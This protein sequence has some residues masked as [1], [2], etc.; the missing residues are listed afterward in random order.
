MI[1]RSLSPSSD[2]IH[3]QG[4]GERADP[5][6]GASSVKLAIAFA[7]VAV[8]C[9][10]SCSGTLAQFYDLTTE[11]NQAISELPASLGVL[12][13]F[14]LLPPRSNPSPLAVSANRGTRAARDEQFVEAIAL[15]S[16]CIEQGVECAQQVLINRALAYIALHDTP[17]AVADLDVVVRGGDVGGRARLVRS[18]LH[19]KAGAFGMA[20]TELE[21][22]LTSSPWDPH[23]HAMLGAALIGA[24][25]FADAVTAIRRSALLDPEGGTTRDHEGHH[26]SSVPRLVRIGGRTRRV[27]SRGCR[28][29]AM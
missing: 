29:L 4:T 7:L 22:V 12:G 9:L 26:H 6:D 3:L 28:H 16:A 23:A 19:L 14:E 11:R 13:Q 25:R 17:R 24:G 27:R 20:E 5:Y 10:S 21:R 8:N 15:F 18:A 2:W 1:W